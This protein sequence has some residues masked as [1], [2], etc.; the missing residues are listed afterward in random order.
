[1]SSEGYVYIAKNKSF[2][3]LKIGSAKDVKIRLQGLNTSSPCD[4]KELASFKVPDSTYFE[5]KVHEALKEFQTNREFFKIKHKDAKSIVEKIINETT[6]DY[7]KSR[8]NNLR[9]INSPEEL[10]DLFSNRRKL[11]GSQK[12]IAPLINLSFNGL[13]KIESGRQEPKLSTIFRMCKMY[14]I[15]ILISQED[16]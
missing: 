13:S 9:E 14:G 7:I 6:D 2:P 4:F 10:V 1:M 5:K 8:N 12:E 15:K 16:D 11:I 3:E